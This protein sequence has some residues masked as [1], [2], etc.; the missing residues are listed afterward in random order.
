MAVTLLFV[1]RTNE[2]QMM[3]E[4]VIYFLYYFIQIMN[5]FIVYGHVLI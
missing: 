2:K 5:K 1:P 3:F 4:K